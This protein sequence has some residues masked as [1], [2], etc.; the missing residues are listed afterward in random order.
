[1]FKRLKPAV[2]IEILLHILFWAFITFTPILSRPR[3]PN[4]RVLFSPWHFVFVNLLLAFQFYLN[5][6][7]DQ[8]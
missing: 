8:Q 5:A 2:I 7:F 3:D 6:F 4:F 1:M